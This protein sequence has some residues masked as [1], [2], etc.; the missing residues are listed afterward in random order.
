MAAGLSLHLDALDGFRE[1]FADEV[2]RQLGSAPPVRELLSDGE[3]PG[4]MLNLS[5]AEAL[6]FAGPWGK[7]FSEPMFD[8]L[9]EVSGVRVVADRHLKLRARAGD[10]MPLEAIGFNLAE[11]R[12]QVGER[13][14]LAYRLD[15]NDYRGLRAPQLVLEHLQAP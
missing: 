10:G 6:R 1:A 14:H 13:M 2:R 3:L 8:G 15:V 5:T 4:E 9:F 7:G 12:A 11:Q